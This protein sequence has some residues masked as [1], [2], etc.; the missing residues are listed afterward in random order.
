MNNEEI[1]DAYRV[2]TWKDWVKVLHKVQNFNKGR[3]FMHIV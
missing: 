3:T 1:R 2:L